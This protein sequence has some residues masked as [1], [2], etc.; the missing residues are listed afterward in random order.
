MG[1][2]MG[3]AEVLCWIAEA[4]ADVKTHV[5]GYLLES[6]FIAF[7]KDTKPSP[8]TVTMGRLVGKI[9]PHRQMVFKLDPKLLSRDPK[10]CEEFTADKLCHDTGT[11]EGLAGNLDR[12]IGLDTGK[13]HVPNKAGKG[14][15]TR[16]W[17]SH[18]TADGV[19][20]YKGTERLYGTLDK[21]DD[22]ELKLYDGWFHKSTFL[23]S[24]AH[25][26]S[27]CLSQCIRS[28]PR[29]RSNTLK[30]SPTGFS[31]MWMLVQLSNLLLPNLSRPR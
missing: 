2:S 16:L 17:L 20:D 8:F 3:G 14:G 25:E 23:A 29:T 30:M 11:L 26:L 27:D 5:T 31:S 1:H 13:I 19:C 7:H 12:A 10:V 6:P 28:Q 24:V 18:G 15:V 9:L 22:K 21:E 4:P